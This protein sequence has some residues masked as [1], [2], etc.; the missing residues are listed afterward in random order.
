MSV[1]IK[2]LLICLAIFSATA[3]SVPRPPGIFPSNPHTHPIVGGWSTDSSKQLPGH[4]DRWVR[5]QK[6]ELL[7]AKV[8][9][10]STQVVAGTN[11]K[12]VYT[13]FGSPIRVW[14]VVV[15][16]QPWTNT[17]NITSFRRIR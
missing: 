13:V 12:I 3:R 8:T 6:P 10:V 14:E 17:K 11:Y 9:S 5:S 1:L 16:D 7:R 4:I 2:L 15:F